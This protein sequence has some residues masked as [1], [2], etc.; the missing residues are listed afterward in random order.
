VL[1]AGSN[2]SHQSQNILQQRIIPRMRKRPALIVDFMQSI[3]RVK[4][5]TPA[6]IYLGTTPVFNYDRPRIQVIID[7]TVRGLFLKHAK[8]RLPNDCAVEDFC[9]MPIL[10]SS[11]QQ[12]IG[13]LPLFTVG[14]GTV[15]SYRYH[16][17]NEDLFES[18]WFLMFYND[19][20]LF[21]T[22]TSR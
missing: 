14:D 17:S 2:D 22:Q 10:D 18:Y 12:M 9:Y 15:F 3:R 21:V 7:K 20:S 19:T 6:G 1:A 11:S 4:I 16:L 8:R 5:H 13:E